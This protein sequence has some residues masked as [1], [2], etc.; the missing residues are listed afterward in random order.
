MPLKG[1][2]GTRVH[3]LFKP[4]MGEES[5]MYKFSRAQKIVHIPQIS[6]L[7]VHFFPDLIF[8]A[9]LPI[10]II[11]ILTVKTIQVCNQRNVAIGHINIQMKRNIPLRLSV[12]SLYA[13]YSSDHALSRHSND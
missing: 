6:I 10:I 11:G 8:R 12:S 4:Y 7:V 2:K 3:T 1:E 9:P 5:R 13:I